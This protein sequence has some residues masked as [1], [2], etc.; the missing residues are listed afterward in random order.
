MDL[1]YAS[2]G[3]VRSASCEPRLAAGEWGRARGKPAESPGA[4]RL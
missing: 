4:G 2:I 1:D 3:A